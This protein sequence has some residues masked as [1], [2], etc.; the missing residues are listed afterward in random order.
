[1]CSRKTSNSCRTISRDCEKF[2]AKAVFSH[3]NANSTHVI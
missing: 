1:M 3:T 2:P